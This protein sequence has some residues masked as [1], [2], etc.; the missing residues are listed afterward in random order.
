[1]SG[2]M[3]L[4]IITPDGYVLRGVETD[5]VN[6]PT[7]EGSIGIL[8]NH[9]PLA[10]ALDT[11]VLRYHLDDGDHQVAVSGGY[12]EVADNVVLVLA[13]AA[14]LD[15]DIDVARARAALRRA[16]ERLHAQQGTVNRARADAALR[17]SLNRL[18]VAGKRQRIDS[19]ELSKI[20][21]R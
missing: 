21:D 20:N 15:S 6:V 16:E 14:E 11:G 8:W 19:K 7:S 9:A 12:L 13:D 2:K 10:A 18:K 4:E 3:K 5:S 17:R 1:M